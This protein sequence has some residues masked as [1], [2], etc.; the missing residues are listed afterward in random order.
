MHQSELVRSYSPVVTRN[1]EREQ[2]FHFTN[3]D[4]CTN[5]S[6]CTC[7]LGMAGCWTCRL[8]K[9]DLHQPRLVPFLVRSGFPRNEQPAFILIFYHRLYRSESHQRQG[10][11][12]LLLRLILSL[13]TSCVVSQ[14]GWVEFYNTK[15]TYRR[16]PSYGEPQQVKKD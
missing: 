3:T 10:R 8:R 6:W 15:L 1:L 12:S 9:G 11:K 4:W 14:Q 16:R 7:T 13:S 5:L 2:M